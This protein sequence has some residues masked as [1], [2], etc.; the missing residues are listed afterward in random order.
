MSEEAPKYEVKV[1]REPIT[2]RLNQEVILLGRSLARTIHGSEDKLGNL[3]ED[4]IKLMSAQQ[5]DEI[6]AAALL[7]TTE[8]I[9]MRRISDRFDSMF[10]EL[11][12]REN[13][14]VERIAGLQAVSAFE[15]CLVELMFKDRLVKSQ[16]EKARYEELRSL[17]AN[18]MKDRLT[19]AGAEQIAELQEQYE[20]LIVQYNDLVDQYNNILSKHKNLTSE[21]EKL[22]QAYKTTLEQKKSLQSQNTALEDY[23]KDCK[24]LIKWHDELI[25]GYVEEQK[26]FGLN[27][28][29]LRQF[30]EAF[31][32][33]NPKPR[34]KE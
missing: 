19:K 5:E 20:K 7:Q 14:M 11:M 4:A 10:K 29:N 32:Q 3:I 17:A 27:K 21:A 2:V 28:K 30:I 1:K 22:G 34:V 26:G 9:L 6:R 13:K 24:E 25:E 8:E 18:K 31:M 16:A 15:T 33:E 12:K 23:I